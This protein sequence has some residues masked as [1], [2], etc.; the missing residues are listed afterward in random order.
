MI[1]TLAGSEVEVVSGSIYSDEV[2]VKRIRDGRI[3]KTFTSELVADGGLQE[4]SDAINTVDCAAVFR[5]NHPD[6]VCACGERKNEYDREHIRKMARLLDERH[7]YGINGNG[8][9]R[10]TVKDM[11][12]TMLDGVPLADLAKD[13]KRSYASIEQMRFKINAGLIPEIRMIEKRVEEPCAEERH[14]NVGA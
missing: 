6:K 2:E 10:W 11:Y 4:I 3:L 14:G 5:K 1:K 12:K 13:L 9:Q 7:N 8:N